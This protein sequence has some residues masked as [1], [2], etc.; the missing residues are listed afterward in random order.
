M[1]SVSR[2]YN[3]ES[4]ASQ[5]YALKRSNHSRTTTFTDYD[6]HWHHS[7][8][9]FRFGIRTE[10]PGDGGWVRNLVRKHWGGMLTLRVD[11]L[12]M[13]HRKQP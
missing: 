5:A 13:L 2:Y 1:Q 7:L 10:L 4:L 6:S 3:Q 9:E 8:H 12:L 11:L